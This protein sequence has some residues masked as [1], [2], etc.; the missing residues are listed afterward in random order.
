V[1]FADL[2]FT[3]GENRIQFHTP[4]NWDGTSNIIFEFTFTND[5]PENQ[6]M[7]EGTETGENIG[8]YANNGTH[9]I[10]DMG[11]TEVPAGPL[12]T[13]SEQITVSF[14]SFG[15]PDFLPAATSII[16]G[17]DDNNNRNLNI[18][19]PWSNS[20][21]YF[22]CGY[23]G[24]GYNRIEKAATPE[25]I[26]GQWNHWAFTKNTT[27]GEMKIFLNGEIWHSGT[28]KTKPISIADLIIGDIYSGTVFWNNLIFCN[29]IGNFFNINSCDYFG[30]R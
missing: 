27:L 11:Y 21:I 10:N 24:G 28:G 13:I 18:H 29:H 1:Y 9:I 22:D 30:D 12:S 16:S 3:P 4:F 6:L 25:E 8:L 26:E 7:I 17:V 2:T 14:W 5:E 23:E 15:S 19:L 20:I